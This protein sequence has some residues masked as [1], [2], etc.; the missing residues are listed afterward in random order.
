MR[1]AA[2]ALPER[3]HPS[4]SHERPW[5]FAF[6]IAPDAVVSLGLVG[7]ALTFLLR[8]EG[9]DPARA[10]S[11]SALIALPHAIYFLWGPITDFWFQRRAWIIIAAIAAAITIFFAFQLPRLGSTWGVS[12]LFL[13]ASIAVLAPAACGGMMA[14][15]HSEVNRRRAGSFYQTGSLAIGA[16]AVFAIASL[17]G[18]V[19]L[20]IL[21]FFVVLLIALPSLAALAAS[22]EPV[23]SEHTW[24]DTFLRIWRECKSTFLRWEAI[25]YTLIAAG[26]A[27]SGAMIGLLGELARDY[28]VSSRQVAWM[29]GIGGALLTSAGALAASF[30]PVRIRA[31]IAFLVAGILNSATLAVLAFGQMRPAVYFTGTV[32]YLFTV[33][34]CYALFTAVILELLGT[35]GKSGSGRYSIINSLGN[36]PVV[37]MT[38]LDGCGYAH[39]GP[40]GMPGIDVI[41]SATAA[42]VLLAH[43]IVSRRHKQTKLIAEKSGS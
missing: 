9:I 23:I 13:G 18:H 31:P 5:L 33:G 26:P 39:W 27:G 21:G 28:G 1:P 41:V 34:A 4:D 12:L 20:R 16:V 36:V 7:G 6:L 22:S 8:N 37:Y 29:N 43:F 35:S 25:P 2:S 11:I 38:W 32:L 14:T 19:S 40:R 17:A 42:S 24:R 30:I 3:E 10:A 15:L